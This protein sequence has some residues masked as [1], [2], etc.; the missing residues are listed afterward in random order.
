MQVTFKNRF[1]ILYLGSLMLLLSQLL[2]SCYSF[3]GSSLSKDVKTVQIKTFPNNTA[4]DPN[5]S[6]KFT[7]D[8]QNRF[9]QRTNLKSAVDMPDLLIEGEIV[10][11][12]ISPTSISSQSSTPNPT[13]NVTL[14]AQNKLTITVKV[15]YENKV[16]PNRSFDR[17][18]SDESVYNPNASI[19]QIESD[20]TKVA[21]DRIINKIFNDIVTNWD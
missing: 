6:Q 21:T 5:L 14:S 7:V 4:F 3:N 17:T 10:D 16:E 1:R 9:L 15:H 12:Q 13:G 20:I 19:Q 8:L 11:Y 2:V 18:Y